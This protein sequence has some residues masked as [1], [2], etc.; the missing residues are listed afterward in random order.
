MQC[1][2]SF[3]LVHVHKRIILEFHYITGLSAFGECI[4]CKCKMKK[5]H[6]HSITW[7]SSHENLGGRFHPVAG[8]HMNNIIQKMLSYCCSNVLF[9]IVFFTRYGSGF[10]LKQ[11]IARYISELLENWNTKT[12]K[13]VNISVFDNLWWVGTDVS[14]LS[15]RALTVMHHWFW[16]PWIVQTVGGGKLPTSQLT[17][18][19]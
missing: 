2:C 6:L 9:G 4:G 16:K 14:V 15:C 17:L 18:R 11:I 19:T 3:I 13:T 1:Y 7:N 8:R 5:S 12:V 10:S